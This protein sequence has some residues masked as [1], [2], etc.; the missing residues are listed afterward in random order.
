MKD[1]VVTAAIGIDSER[2][3]DRQMAAG[4]GQGGKS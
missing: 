2:T 4:L 1:P 3:G